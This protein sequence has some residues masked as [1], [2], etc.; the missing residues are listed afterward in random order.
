MTV[1]AS[2]SSKQPTSR[3]DPPGFITFL[4]LV[5]RRAGSDHYME[6]KLVGKRQAR[7]KWIERRKHR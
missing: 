4:L 7:D 6:K 1:A 3:I 5:G 2:K